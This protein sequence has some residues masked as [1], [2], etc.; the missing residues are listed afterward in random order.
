MPSFDPYQAG[1][2]NTL[3]DLD[4][5]AAVVA[6]LGARAAR[7]TLDVARHLRDAMRDGFPTRGD[8]P[9]GENPTSS[10]DPTEQAGTSRDG[11]S[12]DLNRLR[13]HL[14]RAKRDLT[15]VEGILDRHTKPAQPAPDGCKS[16]AR[17]PR[18]HKL[19]RRFEPVEENRDLC[20]F[21]RRWTDANQG[22]WPPLRIVEAHHQGK[23]MT[24]SLLAE[25]TPKRG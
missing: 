2:T 7:S 8:T 18:N 20:R 13:Q 6:E 11:A 17:L 16:C 3:S 10:G 24:P 9:A 14:E 19:P 12:D 5:L 22:E 25:L 15:A 1:K 21:C 23:R 4:R